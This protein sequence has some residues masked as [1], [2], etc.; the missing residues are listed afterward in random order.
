MKAILTRQKFQDKQTEGSIVLKDD[1]DKKVFS[2]KTLELPWLDNAKNKSCIPEG[3]YCVVFR[4]SAKYGSH[5]HVQ[6][7]PNRN[8]ILIHPGNFHWQ[9]KGCILIGDNLKDIDGDEYKDVTNSIK[10]MKQLLKLAPG[11]F[12]LEIKSKKAKKDEEVTTAD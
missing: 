10:T 4:D 5:F 9:I 1:D 3:N 12:E 6:D 8:Y 7:V 2:C 11:G